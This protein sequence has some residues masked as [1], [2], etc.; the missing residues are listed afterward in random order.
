[1]SSERKEVWC[2]T[3]IPGLQIEFGYESLYMCLYQGQSLVGA[4]GEIVLQNSQ[5]GCEI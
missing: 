1:M 4:Q 2:N 5:K 3:Q